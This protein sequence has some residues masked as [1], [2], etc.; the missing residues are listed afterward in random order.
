MARG[1]HILKAIQQKP[2]DLLSLVEQQLVLEAIMS[3]KDER[4]ID[5]EGLKATAHE[6]A[7]EVT[8]EEDY[9]RLEKE[10]YAQHAAQMLAEKKPEAQAETPAPVATA[11]EKK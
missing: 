8:S 9:D 6:R 11:K 2:E 4:A 7:G 1:R 10:L 5:V 3:S